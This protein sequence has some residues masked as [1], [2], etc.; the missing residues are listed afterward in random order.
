VRDSYLQSS[1]EYPGFHLSIDWRETICPMASLE[2]RPSHESAIADTTG[3]D[4][5]REIQKKRD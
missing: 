1:G 3:V 5:F 2:W 4:F